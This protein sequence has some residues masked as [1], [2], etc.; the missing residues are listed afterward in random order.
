MLN[1]STPSRHSTRSDPIPTSFSMHTPHISMMA[2]GTLA[3]AEGFR[4]SDVLHV[5]TSVDD[6]RAGD[7]HP[8]LGYRL[9]RTKHRRVM[10]VTAYVPGRQKPAIERE[11]LLFPDELSREGLFSPM[12]PVHL[13]E[14]EADVYAEALYLERETTQAQ[15]PMQVSY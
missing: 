8:V 6:L 12:L 4:P 1:S 7:T 3:L 2:G 11:H 13:R 10:S 9:L 15:V 14:L 5:A